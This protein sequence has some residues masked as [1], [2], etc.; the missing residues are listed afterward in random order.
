MF[1]RI[2]VLCAAVLS[3]CA[4]T[5]Q[6]DLYEVNPATA[7]VVV[8]AAWGD[9]PG[10]FTWPGDGWGMREVGSFGTFALDDSGH[11]YIADV[12]RNEVKIY[13][14][15]G[16]FVEALPLIQGHSSVDDLAV[17]DGGIYWLRASPW[18]GPVF[19]VRPGSSELIEIQVTGDAYPTERHRPNTF[20]GRALVATPEGLEVLVQRSGLS[21]PLLRGARLV[22]VSEQM[23]G[24]HRGLRTPSGAG[25]RF[26]YDDATTLYGERVDP[27]DLVRVLQ[28]GSIERVLAKNTSWPE[29]VEG[30]YLLHIDCATV[31]DEFRC[32]FVVVDEYGTLLSRTRTLKHGGKRM[33]DI[34]NRYRLAPDGSFYGLYIDDDGVRVLCWE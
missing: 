20:Y 33:I 16:D 7:H 24:A 31:E 11:I 34:S 1:H 14:R 8:D 5:S 9:G 22:P 15:A 19:G 26:N 30:K 17:Y 25:I 23:A 27:G 13:D 6:A 21:V 10:D 2:I 3:C 32:Y 18:I 12:T 29:G 4:T 28:D